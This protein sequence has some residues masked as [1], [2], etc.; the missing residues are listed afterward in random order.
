MKK[1][2]AKS[3]RSKSLAQSL[4]F[5]TFRGS[6][7]EDVKFIS[8]AD[9]CDGAKLLKAL[10][11]ITKTLRWI[12]KLKLRE[13]RAASKGVMRSFKTKFSTN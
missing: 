13:W 6:W 9:N 11:T 10:K 3:F 1:E 12:P 8:G 5:E 2:T 4:E 7:V